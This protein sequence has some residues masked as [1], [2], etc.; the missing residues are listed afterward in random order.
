MA[1]EIFLSSVFICTSFYVFELRESFARKRGYD[2]RVLA[3]TGATVI[4]S[5]FLRCKTTRFEAP[6]LVGAGPEVHEQALRR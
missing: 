4:S 6:C 3:G 1:R 2:K 5:A